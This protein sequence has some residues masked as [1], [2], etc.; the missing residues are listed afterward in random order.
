VSLSARDQEDF[1]F[2]LA[3]AREGRQQGLDHFIHLDQPVGILNYIR[4]ANDIAARVPTGRLLDWGCGL[5]QMTWLLRRRGFDVVPF[6]IAV[7]AEKIPDLPLTRG[8][9]VV[10]GTHPTNLPFADGSFDAVLSCGVLEHVDEFTGAGNEVESL[11]EIHRVLK[12]DGWFP[13]YQLPQ[14]HTWQ[15]AIT[16]ALSVGYS[17]PRRFTEREARDLL[18]RCSFAVTAVRRYNMLPKNLTGVPHALRD[19]YSRFGDAVHAIDRVHSTIP[20]LNRV[21]GVLEILARRR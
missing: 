1:D 10:Q 6:D 17:H 18:A 14:Q 20:G 16:R 21:A 4:I 13:I 19:F 5:G 15:E 8:L 3:T 9:N 7:T 12:P 2:L 11:H